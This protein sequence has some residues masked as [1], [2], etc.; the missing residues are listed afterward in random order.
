MDRNFLKQMATNKRGNGIKN[1]LAK[2]RHWNKK[3]QINVYMK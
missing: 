2:P 3:N 1:S